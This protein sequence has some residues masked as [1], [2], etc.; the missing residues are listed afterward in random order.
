MCQNEFCHLL[1]SG[2]GRPAFCNVYSKKRN[3]ENTIEIYELAIL[4]RDN[5]GQ[6]KESTK[7]DYI[8][9]YINIYV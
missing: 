1:K 8:Y 7:L 4:S 5:E 9:D 6:G 2:P 3:K